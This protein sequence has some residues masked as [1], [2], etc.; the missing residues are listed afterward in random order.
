MLVYMYII[1]KLINIALYITFK[2]KLKVNNNNDDF[3]FYPRDCTHR[4]RNQT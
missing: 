3:F 2:D 1:I 4:G